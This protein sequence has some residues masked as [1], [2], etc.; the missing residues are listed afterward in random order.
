MDDRAQQFERI[1]EEHFG[2]VWNSLRR[3]GVYERNLEDVCHEVL[4]IVY[5]KLDQYD[6]DRPL[7]PWLF[8][9][10][11]RVASD[12]R[13]KASNARELLVDP[14]PPRQEAGVLDQ[15]SASDARDVVMRAIQHIDLERRAVFVLA[16]LDG[17]AMPAIAE[18]LSIPVDTAYSRLRKARETFERA[19]REMLT[20]D[21]AQG[22]AR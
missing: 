5:D 8:G 6:P 16:E 17:H 22:V 11:F 14:E 15:L 18:S 20:Q 21:T 13:A 1:Y 19:V 3:L 2:Y 7:R 12:H 4:M 9:I 10:A